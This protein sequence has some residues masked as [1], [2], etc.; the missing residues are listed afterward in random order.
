MNHVTT[1]AAETE[2]LNEI[3]RELTGCPTGHAYLVIAVE[4]AGM[5]DLKAFRPL[6]ASTIS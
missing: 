4:P 6:P 3:L 5:L 1:L 2:S